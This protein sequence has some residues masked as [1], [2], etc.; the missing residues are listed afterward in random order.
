MKSPSYWVYRATC[1]LI[2]LFYPKPT[3]EGLEHLPEGACVIVGNHAQMNGPIIADIYLPGDRS[4][5]CTS[6]MMHLREVPAYAYEDFWWSKKP[7][8]VRW[9]YKIA[10]YAIAPLSVCIFNNAHCIGV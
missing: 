1:G 5:W 8:A 4:I 6:E 7:I 2:R 9:L 10:S 3:L